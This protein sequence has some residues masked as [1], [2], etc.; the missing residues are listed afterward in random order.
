MTILALTD[1]RLQGCGRQVSD[2]ISLRTWLADRWAILFSHPDDFAEEQLEMDRWL[3]ILSRGFRTCGVVPVALLRAGH[4]AEKGWLGQLAAS[5]HDCAATLSLE[6]PK[7]ATLAD[8]AAG[9]LRADIN[10]SG[11]RF[12]MIIDP[13]LRCRR[14]LSYRLPRELPSPLDL[15]G[16]SVALRKK[17]HAERHTR[18]APELL[19]PF[20]SGCAQ[21][22]RYGVA[23]AI[24]T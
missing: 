8:F 10:R 14:S 21:A 1:D 12:A 3:T 24:R 17:D 22:L 16:W 11:P 4:D 5:S 19:P 6:L 15:I 23:Q 20:R 7:P 13:E 9:A 2:G 18:E